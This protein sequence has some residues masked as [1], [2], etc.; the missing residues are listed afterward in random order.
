MYSGRKICMKTDLNSN[1]SELGLVPC[2]QFTL[3]TL[4]HV[5]VLVIV[6]W[7]SRRKEKKRK[8]EGR[9]MFNC[10]QMRRGVEPVPPGWQSE[11]F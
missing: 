4:L 8:K 2:Y 9:P 10:R 1:R 7:T 5:R 3:A 11:T 6:T